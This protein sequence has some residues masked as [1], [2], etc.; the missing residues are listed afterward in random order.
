MQI[1]TKE[2]ANVSWDKPD[3]NEI[4]R[5]N[6]ETLSLQKFTPN[7]GSKRENSGSASVK[8]SVLFTETRYHFHFWM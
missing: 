7:R 1:Y 2:L 5:E 3:D 8:K 6:E 4:F